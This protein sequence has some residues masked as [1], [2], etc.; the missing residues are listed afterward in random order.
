VWGG[1]GGSVCVCVCV[2]VCLW[3]GVFLR[4]CVCVIV[5]LFALERCLFA[6]PSVCPSACLSL[7]LSLSV[8]MPVYLPVCLSFCLS[9]CRSFC[10]TPPSHSQLHTCSSFHSIHSLL[11]AALHCAA[12]Q[13]HGQGEAC[14]DGPEAGVVRGDAAA[15]QGSRGG[16]V[17]RRGWEGGRVGGSILACCM[18]ELARLHAYVRWFRGSVAVVR[19]HGGLYR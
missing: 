5:S 1:G 2:G 8:C 19:G 9:V 6:C 14:V 18:Y 10:S 4:F 16:L 11:L 17:S 12:R 13:S 3:E 7:G 15:Q